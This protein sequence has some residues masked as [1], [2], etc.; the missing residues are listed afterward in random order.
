MSIRH[1][2]YVS[3]IYYKLHALPGIYIQ[4]NI[5]YIHHVGGVASNKDIVISGLKFMVRL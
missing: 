1:S 5:Q 4:P 2:E 3:E